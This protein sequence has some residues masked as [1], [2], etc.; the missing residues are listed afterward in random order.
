MDQILLEKLCKEYNLGELQCNPARLTGG[1]THKMYSLF[2]TKGKYAV[3]LL[4]P[5]I[6]RRE[7]AMG[8]YRRAEAFESALEQTDIPILPALT[9][10]GEKM[11][12]VDGQYFYL[13]TWFDGKAL[14][15]EE[16]T[17]YHCEKI[18]GIL[19]KIHGL[20]LPQATVD[21][22]GVGPDCGVEKYER[23]ELHVGT[24]GAN[25]IVHERKACRVRKCYG[26]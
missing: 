4:N 26:R 25:C 16:I 9:F 2:T 22:Q 6:M 15:S 8:N 1:F 21:G 14:K 3:K 23:D 20:R 18:G 13:Y 12:C 24:D 17:Q 11:Q 10:N 7:T 5:F 19:A